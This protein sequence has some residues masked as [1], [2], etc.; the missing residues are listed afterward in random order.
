MFR[1]A[2]SQQARGP[3][4][5]LPG[6]EGDRAIAPDGQPRSRDPAFGFGSARSSRGRGGAESAFEVDETR[7]AIAR[8]RAGRRRSRN[9]STRGLVCEAPPHRPMLRLK[10][11]MA[12][13][14]ANYC[15]TGPDVGSSM[16]TPIT[17]ER[18]TSSHTRS[19]PAARFDQ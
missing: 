12:H 9:V 6:A 10:E 2:S 7:R 13:P 11:P 15:T 5:R 19:S 16:R 17:S 8:S 4:G 3:S 1:P 18:N 14:Q